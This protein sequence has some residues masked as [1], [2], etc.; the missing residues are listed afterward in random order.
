MLKVIGWIGLAMAAVPTMLGAGVPSTM[1]AGQVSPAAGHHGASC[2][3]ERCSAIGFWAGETRMVNGKDVDAPTH[4][5]APRDLS[6]YTP[7]L[8]RTLAAHR[9]PLYLSLNYKRDFG[10]VPAGEHRATDG[11][12]LIRSAQ[13]YGVPV[14]AWLLVPYQDG[15][16]AGAA[17][18][19]EEFAAI[20]AFEAWDHAKRLGID[21]VVVDSEPPIQEVGALNAAVSNPV[22]L[23]ALARENIDPARQCSSTA[24][25]T[26]AISWGR[27]HG[28]DVSVTPLFLA[29]DE[30]NDGAIAL[31][32]ALG[33]DSFPPR[34]WSTSYLQVYRSTISSIFGVDPGPGL[35]ASYFESMRQDFGRNGQVSLGIAGDGPYA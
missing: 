2:S 29:V 16:W 3:Q 24:V 8:W 13:R 33:V 20:R 4:Y 23:V 6:I 18:A 19:A 27:T 21:E 14:K 17:N 26:R 1:V 32:G 12:D 11:L 25:Y 5:W 22:G 31:Q 28:L 9:V 34:T 30:V 35:A 15:Y 7:K 10:P